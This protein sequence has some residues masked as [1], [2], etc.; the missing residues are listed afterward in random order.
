MEYKSF[1]SHISCLGDTGLW[2]T[3]WDWG[4]CRWTLMTALVG[5]S[6]VFLASDPFSTIVHKSTKREY[7]VLTL[8]LHQ[9]LKENLNVIVW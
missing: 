4:D 2:R 5:A 1:M 8:E 3:C 6:T 9:Y 7:S